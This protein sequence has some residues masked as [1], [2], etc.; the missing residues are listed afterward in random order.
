MKN[1]TDKNEKHNLT[2]HK[3]VKNNKDYEF[4]FCVNIQNIKN[5][6]YFFIII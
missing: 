1:R 6:Q 3:R 4:V 2:Q 5:Q